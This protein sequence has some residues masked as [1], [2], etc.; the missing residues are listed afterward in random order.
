MWTSSTNSTI[1]N[2]R[3]EDLSYAWVLERARAA[4]DDKAVNTLE[5]LGGSDTY[6]KAGKFAERQVL[7]RYGGLMRSDPLKMVHLMFE[8]PEYSFADC[9]RSFRMKALS[10]SIPLMAEELLSFD[11]AK[12][13]RKL[14]VPVYFFLG[15]HDHTA[16][17][18]LSEDLY[19]S[20]QAPHKELIWFENSAHTPDLDETDK[21]QQEVVRI[22]EQVCGDEV[23]A[24]KAST[25]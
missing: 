21:F 20:L 10:F 11:L 3:G 15:R 19:A 14:D 2:R 12:D 25:A 6:S 22:G 17:P 13:V 8:A 16:P 1:D 18:E 4:G 5:Q 7:F 24:A 23:V 9:L